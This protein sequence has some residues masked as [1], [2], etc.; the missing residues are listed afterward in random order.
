M[1]SFTWS[2]DNNDWIVLWDQYNED[3][4][5]RRGPIKNGQ[6]RQQNIKGMKKTEETC[7]KYVGSVKFNGVPRK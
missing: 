7:S 4:N 6:F 5:N 1:N 2:T 3:F